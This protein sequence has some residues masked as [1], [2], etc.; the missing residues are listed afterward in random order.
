[1]CI[2]SFNVNGICLVVIKGVFDWLCVQ[3]VDVVCLQEIKVQED[4]LIDVMFCLDGYYCF[5]CDVISKKGYSGVVIYVKCELDVVFIELGWDEFDNE[6][7]YIE[8]CF[9]K[10]LVV[11]LYFLFGLFGEECQQFKF[12]VMDWIE[13]IF[14][15][16]LKS[17]CQYVICGD[18]N[19][20]CSEK[21]IKN[22][23][24]NQKNFGCLL[25]ECVWFN[26]LV[27]CGWVDSYCMFKFEGEDYIW[28]FNCGCVCEND[29]GWCIDYQIFLLLLCEWLCDCVIYCEQC[30]FDYVFYVVDYVD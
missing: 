4:Q 10:L 23:K 24:F 29:V 25:E 26:G 19:I 27:E 20:V 5:Y 3:Y 17:D 30:F 8:V 13:L 2:I 16:W 15:G 14:D 28:W 1:M 11:L 9:G 7:C 12:C 6:G 21:D 22:W 18:W